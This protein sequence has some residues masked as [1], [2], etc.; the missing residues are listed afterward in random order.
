M[1]EMWSADNNGDFGFES[2]VGESLGADD[3]N[4]EDDDDDDEEDD[5]EEEDDN[6][7]WCLSVVDNEEIR[8]DDWEYNGNKCWN[9]SGIRHLSFSFSNISEDD[10]KDVSIYD[11]NCEFT[12]D[13]HENS[14]FDCEDADNNGDT[15]C[16]FCFDVAA[17]AAAAAAAADACAFA[18]NG[19]IDAFGW[20][21]FNAS[22]TVKTRSS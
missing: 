16:I 15:V 21:L 22:L 6:D 9:F 3:D 18:A 14:D 8:C 5:D 7:C 17:A 11:D 2:N 1:C 19:H 10:E 13:D 4:D 20:E 12:H